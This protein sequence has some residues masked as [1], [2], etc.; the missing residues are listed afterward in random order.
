MPRF[1]TYPRCYVRRAPE[2]IGSGQVEGDSEL[3]V[4]WDI[5]M[6]C[7]LDTTTWGFRKRVVNTA[8]RLFENFGS[9]VGDQNSSPNVVGYN[10]DFLADTLNFIETGK[11]KLHPLQWLDIVNETA[12]IATVDDN[13][14][15]AG[16]NYKGLTFTHDVLQKWMSWPLGFEDLMLSL[17][18]FFGGQRN[19]YSDAQAQHY[20]VGVAD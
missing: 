18:I 12:E 17:Y 9:W 20:R 5:Y 3:M 11:R 13:H 19:P 8:M 10:A 2:G 16:G 6:T 4:L 14:T 1:V 15:V 7:K